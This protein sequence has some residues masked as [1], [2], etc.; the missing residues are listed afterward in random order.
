M[1]QNEPYRQKPREYDTK[2][3]P[4]HWKESVDRE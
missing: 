4:K 2:A 3:S 1:I